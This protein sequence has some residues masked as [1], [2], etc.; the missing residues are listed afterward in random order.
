LPWPKL[1]ALDSP[2]LNT[3]P[4]ATVLKI[5][6]TFAGRSSANG[7]PVKSSEMQITN[8]M[9]GK[10]LGACPKKNNRGDFL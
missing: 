6:W 8:R 3:L 7:P 9:T 10:Y 4:E 1:P 5:T 2:F